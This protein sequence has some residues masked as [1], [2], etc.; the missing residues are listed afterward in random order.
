MTKKRFIL[1]IIL[2][3]LLLVLSRKIRDV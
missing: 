1:A 3:G 2:G